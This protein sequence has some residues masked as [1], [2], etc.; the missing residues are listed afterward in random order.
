MYI[1]EIGILMYADDIVLL[2]E[3]EDLQTLLN[4]EGNSTSKRKDSG[5]VEMQMY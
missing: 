5:R 4:I 3:C 1:V 2:A